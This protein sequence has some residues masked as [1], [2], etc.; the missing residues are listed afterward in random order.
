MVSIRNN[1]DSGHERPYVQITAILVLAMVLPALC[2]SATPAAGAS[3]RSGVIE[4]DVTSEFSHVRVRRQGSIRSLIFVRD[5][6]E[7]AV[8]TALN[9]SKPH[10][11]RVPYMQTM[12]ASYLFRPQA[13]HVLIVGLGG[14]AMVQFLKHH[15]PELRIDAVEID[16]VVV[17]IADQHFGTRS[18]GNVNI[19]TAD[20]FKYL[21]ETRSLYDVIYMDAFLKP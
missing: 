20:A 19:V 15:Q 5:N 21:N 3:R 18:G 8:E 10:Q 7:E 14:G 2:P 1:G 13:Q 17:K 11:L 4:V 12:F 6:G 16:P 9:V